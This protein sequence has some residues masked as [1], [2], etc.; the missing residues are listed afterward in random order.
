MAH[1]RLKIKERASSGWMEIVQLFH[2]GVQRNLPGSFSYVGQEGQVGA[3]HLEMQCS[4]QRRL[5]IM[6]SS[7][8]A[9]NNAQRR[10]GSQLAQNIGKG[11][12]SIYLSIW[13]R[14]G[15]FPVLLHGVINRSVTY[16]GIF[17]SAPSPML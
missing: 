7:K 4:A 6:L 13:D 16:L 17:F 10:G 5:T 9:H 15:R 14:V 2:P 1:N 3:N 11:S 12:F 8:E